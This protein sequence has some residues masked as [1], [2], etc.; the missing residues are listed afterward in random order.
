M[1]PL[2]IRIG[3]KAFPL[4]PS[5]RTWKVNKQTDVCARRTGYF[6]IPDFGSTGHMI[7]KGSNRKAVISGNLCATEMYAE[8][9]QIGAYISFSRVH[10]PEGL[11]LMEPFAPFVFQKG[12]PFGPGLLLK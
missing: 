7:L 11:R 8:D 9:K 4:T 5:S 3:N 1:S 6:L 12:A 2:T 10:D